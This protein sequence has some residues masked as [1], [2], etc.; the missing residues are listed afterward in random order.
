ME[1]S[2]LAE[3]E[4]LFCTKEIIIEQKIMIFKRS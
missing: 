1:K 2:V 3:N 4:D